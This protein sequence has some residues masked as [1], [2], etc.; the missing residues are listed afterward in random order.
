MGDGSISKPRKYLLVFSLAALAIV[1]I[2]LPNSQEW[3]DEVLSEKQ[4]STVTKVVSFDELY[5]IERDQ[6][7]LSHELRSVKNKGWLAREV[8]N[9]AIQIGFNQDFMLDHPEYDLIEIQFPI[10]RYEDD[11]NVIEFISDEG[12]IIKVRSNNEWESLKNN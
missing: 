12:V 5:W 1:L 10:T 2:S 9:G 6:R 3:F 11:G 7:K 4:E 8:L